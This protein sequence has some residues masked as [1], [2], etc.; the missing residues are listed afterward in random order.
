MRE[1]L[2]TQA[3]VFGYVSY[4]RNDEGKMCVSKDCLRLAS[5]INLS[6]KYEV[7]SIS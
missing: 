7:L 6:S 3:E 2:V 5:L 1:I 4:Q